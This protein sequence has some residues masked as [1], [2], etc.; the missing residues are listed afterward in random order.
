[1][2]VNIDEIKEGGLRRSWDVPR[3]QLDE[4]LAGDRASSYGPCPLARTD[5]QGF[6]RPR[7][8]ARRAASAFVETSIFS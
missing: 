8:T 5:G 7:A 2:R 6:T 3:E 4:M 1:M